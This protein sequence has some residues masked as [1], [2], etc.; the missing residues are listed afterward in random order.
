MCYNIWNFADYCSDPYVCY[1]QE[2]RICMRLCVFSSGPILTTY[3][4]VLYTIST[5]IDFSGLNL[6]LTKETCYIGR[7]LQKE[8]SLIIPPLLT[9]SLLGEWSFLLL[10]NILLSLPPTLEIDRRSGLSMQ[11]AVGLRSSPIS[12]LWWPLGLYGVC[13]GMSSYIH[14]KAALYFFKVFFTGQVVS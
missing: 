2:L 11:M 9:C 6:P 13:E 1:V 3:Q 10:K 14:N 4:Q 7:F 12:W 5:L 8:F